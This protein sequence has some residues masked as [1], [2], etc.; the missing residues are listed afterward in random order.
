MCG[1]YNLVA[2]PKKIMAQ[3][4]LSEISEYRIDYNI[5]PGS[6]ILAITA[7]N[8]SGLFH[9]GLVPFWAKEKQSPYSLINARVETI[10][11]S[12]LS[13]QPLKNA[14]LLFRLQGSTNGRFKVIN[15]NNLS[16]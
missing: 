14:I 3:F 13:G 8:H 11:K 9:W 2:S 12:L 15:P 4:S 16:T 1:R 5:N 7:N 6:N 10:A